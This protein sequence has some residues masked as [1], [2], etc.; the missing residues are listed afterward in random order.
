MSQKRDYYEVLGISK[1]A[2]D[3]DIKTAFRKLAMQ[4]HPDRNSD[5]PEAA[6]KFKEATEAYDILSNSEKRNAYDRFGFSGVHSDFSSVS[7]GDFSTISDL[8]SSLF[9]EDFMGD[10]LFSQFFGGRR[11]SRPSGPQKGSDLLMNYQISFTEAIYGTQKILEVPIKKEC[12]R[13]KGSGAQ[14]GTQPKKCDNCQGS[15]IETVTR[16]M[17]FT[18]YISQ[19]NCSRC[20]GKGEKID[21]PCKECKGS[22][23]SKENEKLKLVIPPGV[24][25]GFRLRIRNKGEE[26]RLS[27]SRG[28][29]Q[30]R[31]IVEPHSFYKRQGDNIIVEIEISF[32]LAIL[33]GELVIPTLYGPEK[34]KI[35]KKT[36]EGSVLRLQRK[37]I[38]RKTQYGMNYGDFLIV[39][40][41]SIPERISEAEKNQLIELNKIMKMPSKQSKLFEELIKESKE[42]KVDY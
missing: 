42:N 2:S 11:R 13:C 23:R 20:Q 36:R 16:Q 5:D 9:R 30:I 7:S 17:G 37:G 29:L 34:V 4:Y 33:G 24:D 41:Y 39:V 15:G 10:D 22:G 14:E 40:H 38:Q 26:G 12:E 31:L 25:S 27:G 21:K 19:Q 3:S 28:D 32:P 18:R 35:P 8:F 6:E 1:D